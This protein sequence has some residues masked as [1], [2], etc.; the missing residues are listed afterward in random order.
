MWPKPIPVRAFKLYSG[1]AFTQ[2]SAGE[3]S[4]S[5]HVDLKSPDGK[6]LF[7]HP[8]KVVFG[9]TSLDVTTGAVD[10]KFLNDNPNVILPPNRSTLRVNV[11]VS[12][13]RNDGFGVSF[14]TYGDGGRLHGGGISWIAYE[15][16]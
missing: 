15:D 1:F 4:K 13:I 5:V 9:F 8:P 14:S 11:G 3:A 16:E 6:P 2:G 7:Q 12:D 10:P